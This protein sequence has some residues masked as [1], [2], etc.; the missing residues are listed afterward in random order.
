MAAKTGTQ[1]VTQQNVHLSPK[2]ITGEKKVS[3]LYQDTSGPGTSKRC[4]ESVSTDEES[5]QM[6]SE[7]TITSV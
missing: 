7:L 1:C 2:E 5:T 6:R 3:S 4:Q